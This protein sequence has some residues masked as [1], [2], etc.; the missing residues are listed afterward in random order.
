MVLV[1]GF[2]AD[3]AL[4][5]FGAPGEAILAE[6]VLYFEQVLKLLDVSGLLLQLH[7]AAH[8]LQPHPHGYTLQPL[9]PAQRLL[10]QLKEGADLL[11]LARV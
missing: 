2:E 1:D 10:L 7:D 8:Y 6:S 5:L 9:Q 4:C 3:D 11:A